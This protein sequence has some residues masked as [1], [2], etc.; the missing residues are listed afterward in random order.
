MEIFSDLIYY[1]IYLIGCRRN[2]L[3]KR[4]RPGIAPL[5]P[6]TLATFRSWGNSAGAGRTRLTRVQIYK[7]NHYQQK[8]I[9]YLNWFI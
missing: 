6:P 5:R 4:V 9:A 8:K 1:N 7:N 2:S 3:Q